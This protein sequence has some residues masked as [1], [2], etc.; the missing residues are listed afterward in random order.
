MVIFPVLPS[1]HSARRHTILTSLPPYFLASGLLYRRQQSRPLPPA[2]SS[3]FSRVTSHQSRITV[4]KSFRFCFYTNCRVSPTGS[5]LQWSY[6]QTGTLPRLISFVCHSYENCRGVGVFFP[7]RNSPLATTPNQFLFKHFDTLC[8]QVRRRCISSTIFHCKP[9]L[10][11][12]QRALSFPRS[13]VHGTRDAGHATLGTPYQS[14]VTNHQSLPPVPLRPPPLGATMTNYQET[15][16]PCPVSK[17]SERTSGPALALRL[18]R[19][20]IPLRS[21]AQ[22]PAKPGSQVVPGSIVLRWTD[23]QRGPGQHRSSDAPFPSGEDGE[24]IRAGKAGSV[25]LG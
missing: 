21:E 19:L 12:G 23:M 1:R 22:F 5:L 13:T 16:P 20:Q 10:R 18:S 7:F 11:S 17:D 9:V 4:C 6:L 8:P 25:R 2:L 15:T 24:M 3:V 14:P